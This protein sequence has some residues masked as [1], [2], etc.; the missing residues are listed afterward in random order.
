MR[1][2]SQEDEKELITFI[3]D[4][5]KVHGYTQRD[6]AYELNIKSSRTSEIILKIKDIYKKGGI[7]NIAKNLI[8]IEQKWINNFQTNQPQVNVTQPY[9]QLDIDSLVNQMNKDSDEKNI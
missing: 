2:L 4:W 8:E 9:N 1:K 3:K 6:L 7:F 5:L